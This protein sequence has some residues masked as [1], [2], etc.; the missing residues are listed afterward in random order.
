[1]IDPIKDNKLPQGGYGTIFVGRLSQEKGVETLECMEGHRISA[2]DSWRWS[3]QKE[4]SENS[5][6]EY[7][8]CGLK[9]TWLSN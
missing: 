9:K 8:I 3:Y 2:Y 5:F 6:R 7:K 1:M 4:S